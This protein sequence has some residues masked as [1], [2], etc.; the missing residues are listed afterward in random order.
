V[1]E[2]VFDTTLA[3]SNETFKVAGVS[4]KNQKFVEIMSGMLSSLALK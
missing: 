2:D 4:E 1:P 3:R